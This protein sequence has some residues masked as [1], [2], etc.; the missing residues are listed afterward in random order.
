MRSFIFPAIAALA[1]GAATPAMAYDSAS[2]LSMQA[3]LDV[4]TGIGGVR[5]RT[6]L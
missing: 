3:A 4:A 6:E 5:C 2:Q 1:I